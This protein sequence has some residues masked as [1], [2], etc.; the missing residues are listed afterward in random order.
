MEWEDLAREKNLIDEMLR[1]IVIEV[2]QDKGGLEWLNCQGASLNP[3][4]RNT[5]P[6]PTIYIQVVEKFAMVKIRGANSQVVVN[7]FVEVAATLKDVLTT[8]PALDRSSKLEVIVIFFYDTHGGSLYV[9]LGD[10]LVVNAR[11]L[12][13]EE[14]Q[15]EDTYDPPRLVLL[16]L[17]IFVYNSAGTENVQA[18]VANS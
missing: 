6:T 13:K 3:T 12:Q 2:E 10:V 18:F 8:L 9:W 15:D 14:N 4:Q 16:A 1:N 11:I 7:F 17:V 5:D